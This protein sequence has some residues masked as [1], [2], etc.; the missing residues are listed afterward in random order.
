MLAIVKPA[1]NLLS[2]LMHEDPSAGANM[3]EMVCDVG[4][5]AAPRAEVEALS[6]DAS[7]LS[8]GAVDRFAASLRTVANVEPSKVLPCDAVWEINCPGDIRNKLFG[9]PLVSMA[10][11][12]GFVVQ[13]ECDAAVVEPQLIGLLRH[14]WRAEVFDAYALQRLVQ[15]GESSSYWHTLLWIG[16][17]LAQYGDQ[18][19][20]KSLIVRGIVQVNPEAPMLIECREESRVTSRAKSHLAQLANNLTAATG[21]SVSIDARAETVDSKWLHGRYLILSD[22]WVVSSDRG[23]DFVFRAKTG[24]RVR[25][26]E[27]VRWFP[28]C[29][30]SQRLRSR[31]ERMTSLL[32]SPI[33]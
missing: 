2:R 27:F 11:D 8:N 24:R 14:Q 21:V 5:L 18:S 15:E 29:F 6:S 28:R 19:R 9:S 3:L 13:D 10:R 22:R 16:E 31:Y 4:W 7:R 12:P 26:N 30:R 20:P 32:T 17:L 25:P 23:F 1:E 33:S